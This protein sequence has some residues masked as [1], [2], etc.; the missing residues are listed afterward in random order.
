MK[1]PRFKIGRA[2]L[3][4]GII[5][6]C[7]VGVV[8]IVVAREPDGPPST[9][10]S[11]DSFGT[12]AERVN[13]LHRYVS[14]R[15]TYES[16]DYR[17]KFFNGGSGLV[18]GPSYGDIKLVA[19]VPASELDAWV[20][21]STRPSTQPTASADREWL[22]SVP[23]KLDLSGVDE[24]YQDGRRTVGLDRTRRIVVYWLD[25]N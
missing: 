18:P 11:S 5:V 8:L 17:I 24:W 23:T 12:L 20:P 9:D 10:T 16:L 22:E 19:T 2:V 15:R 13:F 14:F 6:V 1:P 3:F 25:V 4:A 21:P 7:C